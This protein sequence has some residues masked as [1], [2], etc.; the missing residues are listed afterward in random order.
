MRRL[1]GAKIS[2]R[3]AA[4]RPVERE[5]CYS[6][7]T[8]ARNPFAQRQ[9][10]WLRPRRAHDPGRRTNFHRG[11]GGSPV[12]RARPPLRAQNGFYI[13]SFDGST[14]LQATLNRR[15]THGGHSPRPPV[16]LPSRAQFEAAAEI[17]R[18]LGDPER[19]RLLLRLAESE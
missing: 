14:E 4:T 12:H 13:L 8:E 3:I 5:R 10:P 6:D 1:F 17:F 18:A 11:P 16:P 19:L 15:S 9:R 7:L 2:A